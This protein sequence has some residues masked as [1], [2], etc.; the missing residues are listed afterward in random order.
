MHT[1]VTS[2]P[3]I[4]KRPLSGSVYDFGAAYQA[5]CVRSWIDA[6]FQVLSVNAP[7][8][9]EIVA[10]LFPNIKVLRAKRDE[11]GRFG[12]PLVP[13]SELID[14]LREAGE[15]F[16]GII[17]ADIR[18]QNFP[19]IRKLCDS[20]RLKQLAYVKRQDIGSPTDIFGRPY[21]FG[22]DAFFFDVEAVS[23]LDLR[24]LTLGVPWWDYYVPLDALFSGIEL[25]EWP[26]QIAQHLWHAQ[27]WEKDLWREYYKLF[28]ARFEQRLSSTLL[29]DRSIT[30]PIYLYGLAQGGYYFRHYSDQCLGYDLGGT[31]ELQPADVDNHIVAYGYFVVDFLHKMSKHVSP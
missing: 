9:I 11:R 21:S 30:D 7:E 14:A 25:F 15:P 22:I 12:R 19:E 27:K 10:G 23:S 24:D 20:L 17:N 31:P 5:Q 29:S 28:R 8:E 13:I 16:G 1:V 6:G 2:I 26:H 18:L 4:T 3:P